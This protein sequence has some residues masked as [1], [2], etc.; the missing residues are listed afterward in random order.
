MTPRRQAV[1]IAEYRERRL[2]KYRNVELLEDVAL[3]LAICTILVLAT[4]VAL[5]S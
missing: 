4:I 1:P 2:R 3:A 5:A